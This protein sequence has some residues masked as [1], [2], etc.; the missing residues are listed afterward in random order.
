VPPRVPA[1][2]LAALLAAAATAC[3]GAG[4]GRGANG[5][6]LVVLAAASLTEAF[7]EIGRRFEAAHPGVRVRFGYDASSTLVRQVVA[8]AP[9][10]VLATADE[11]TMQQAVDGGGVDAPAVFA[12]NRLALVVRHG[13]P[14]GI[15]SLADLARPGLVVVLCAEQVPCGRLGRHA[16]ERAGV[17]AQPRSLEPNVKGVVS[18][19]LLGEADAGIAYVTDVMA[20][21]GA[22]EGVPVPDH[23]NVVAIY[24]IAVARAAPDRAAADAF[25]AYVRS[26]AG[27][28]VLERFGFQPA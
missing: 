2:L 15:R 11:L 9:A 17:R 27:Q 6:S 22:V 20:A 23:H 10:G 16:L 19:V 24:P 12:R 14:E 1:A 7:D 4:A 18:K 5:S 21:A 28:S 25:V 3:G 8:G 13:N 26:P